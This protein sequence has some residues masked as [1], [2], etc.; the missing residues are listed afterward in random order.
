MDTGPIHFFHL[1]LSLNFSLLSDLSP[2]SSLLRW[3]LAGEDEG[4]TGNF[5]FSGEKLGFRRA[6][7]P[8]FK[9]FY[10][11]LFVFKP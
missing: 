4:S 10:I 2:L 9:F 7:H 6:K 1:S 3:L 5:I 8:E 11:F